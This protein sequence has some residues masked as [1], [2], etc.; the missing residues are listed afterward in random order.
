M[1]F[2]MKKKNSIH[3]KGTSTPYYRMRVK[4]KWQKIIKILSIEKIQNWSHMQLQLIHS[5]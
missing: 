1:L 3:G 2:H 5:G 4:E